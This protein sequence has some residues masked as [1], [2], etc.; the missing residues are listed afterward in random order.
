MRIAITLL[1]LAGVTFTLPAF[2]DEPASPSAPKV[3]APA[4]APAQAPAPGVGGPVAPTNA[5][6]LTRLH[7]GLT[8]D[9]ARAAGRSREVEMAADANGPAGKPVRP[10]PSPR[11]LRRLGSERVVASIGPAIAACASESKSN[12]PTAFGVRVSIGPEGEV[13]SAEIASPVRPPPALVACVVK[14]VSASRFGSPG[15]A[16][17]S[18]VVPITVPARTASAAATPD[19]TTTTTTTSVIATA[20][21]SAPVATGPKTDDAAR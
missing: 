8:A 3:A 1:A 20:P 15:A 16:G 13:E 18:I 5:N 4:A 2:A 7:G 12:A 19:A 21:A 17:A 10:A 14:A 9:G 6:G 11:V